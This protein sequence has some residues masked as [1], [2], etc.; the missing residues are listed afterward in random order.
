MAPT[1][2]ATTR[3]VVLG[4]A[5]LDRYGVVTRGS[6]TDEGVTG[7]FALAYKV[8]SRF[9]DNGR[10][11]RGYFVAGLGAAQFSTTAIVD[12][13]RGE[14][15]SPDV[16][17]WP[18]GACEPEVFVLAAC[19]PANP[20]G[21]ALPWPVKGPTRAAGALVVIVDGLLVAHLTRGGR[22]LT[23]LF[24]CL[25]AGLDVSAEEIAQLVAKALAGSVAGYFDGRKAAPRRPA[26]RPFV[27]ETVNGE[28]VLR[29][30]WLAAL[31]AA[32]A[33]ITP[34]GVKIGATASPRPRA[35]RGRELG[36]ALESLSFDDPDPRPGLDEPVTLDGAGD[37]AQDQLPWGDD[38]DPTVWDAGPGRAPGSGPTGARPP[39]PFRGRRAPA[40]RRRPR[41][42]NRNR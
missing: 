3:S 5:W 24:D 41:G 19:D 18:S 1:P 25:P 30:P 17:G 36:A 34:R 10:A 14:A 35:R 11:M 15:D 33:E 27:I 6:V 20:Y 8:L 37:D 13:L 7:G 39:G 40:P 32:G 16:A 38:P 22:T 4:E 26:G 21:A 31:R 23:L 29:S 28:P 9:E 12:R 2:D 42:G